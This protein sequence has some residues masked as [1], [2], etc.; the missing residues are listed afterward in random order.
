MKVRNKM[1]KE[2]S[3]SC[4]LFNFYD[5]HDVWHFLSGAGVFFAFVFS[6]TID[7]DLKFTRT[8]RLRIF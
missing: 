6:L 8:D 4:I 5:R 3:K 2:Q 1:I 7:D